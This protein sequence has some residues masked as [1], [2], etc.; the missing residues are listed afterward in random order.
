[1]LSSLS[2]MARPTLSVVIPASD[3][4]ATLDQCLAAI[5]AAS[6]PPEEVVVVDRQD[7]A[8]PASARNAGVAEATGDVIVFVDA[9]VEVH[10]DAFVRIRS[11]FDRRPD[12]AAL[13]GS[14]DDAPGSGTVTGFRNLLHHHVHQGA[15][16]PARTFWA[17]L[18]AMRRQTFAAAGGFSEH[19]IEDIELGMRLVDAG[20]S[21]EL[22]P[23]IQGKHLKAWT[24]W[25]MIR[26]DLVVRGIPW[27]KLLLRH[28]TGTSSLNL[29]WRHRLSA[30]ASLA[31]VAGAA[32]QPLIVALPALALMLALNSSFYALLVRRRGVLQAIGGIGL[33]LVHHLVAVLALAL[34]LTAY[35]LRRER[36]ERGPEAAAG[37]LVPRG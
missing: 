12:L 2:V 15:P 35:A 29:G 19:P 21:I 5:A 24:L 34:G 1:M 11:S 31:I 4:P 26:T 3:R 25:S 10:E 23:A 6:E 37:V 33:H 14:Y 9:D 28:R 13:F 22:D 32:L 36:R 8:S 30:L 16:G 18:G 27:V 17:G 20:A 7:L